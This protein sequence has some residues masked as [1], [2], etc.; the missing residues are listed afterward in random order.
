[1]SQTIKI[2]GLCKR[3]GR[4]IVFNNL[5]AEINCGRVIGLIGENGAGKTTLLRL[6]AGILH[7]DKG[8]VDFGEMQGIKDRNQFI[9]YLMEPSQFYPWMRVKDIINFYDDFF[10]D[11]D[12]SKA[13]K[14]CSRYQINLNDKI[15]T[16]SKGE[17]ERVSIFVCLSRNTDIYLLDEPAGGID[18]K[19]KRE[20]VKIILESTDANKT[21]IISTHL[22]RDFQNVFDDVFI[23]K[24]GEAIYA[25]C[26]DIRQKF[27]KSVE[28][29]YL[30]V[31]G[32]D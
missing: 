15:K 14:Y 23:L 29:Y 27:N 25:S 16:L 1:M 32:N 9:S 28:D 30:E 7:S 11:F 21:I 3:Y 13:L 18:P 22:L 8:H 6:M 5:N 19:F 12:K 10:K 31:M 4:K 26:D 17:Q 2:E 24:R 20:I